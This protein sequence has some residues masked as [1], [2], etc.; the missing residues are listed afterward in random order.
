MMQIVEL[1]YRQKVT[2]DPRAVVAGIPPEVKWRCQ[3]EE[4][5]FEPKRHVLDINPGPPNAAGKRS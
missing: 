4:A 5:L 2:C 3:F 1:L